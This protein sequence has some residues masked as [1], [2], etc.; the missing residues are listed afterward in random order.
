MQNACIEVF[1]SIIHV[2]NRAVDIVADADRKREITRGRSDFAPIESHRVR[3]YIV[4]L[5]AVGISEI[6][7]SVGNVALVEHGSERNFK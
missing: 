7:A 5:T 1:Y 2:V 3:S 4:V 6:F